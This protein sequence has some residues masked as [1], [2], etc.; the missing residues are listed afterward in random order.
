MKKIFRLAAIF[1][2]ISIILSYM[3]IR[4]ADVTLTAG[5]YAF[6]TSVNPDSVST[7]NAYT[8]TPYETT[9]SAA[10]YSFNL[11]NLSVPEGKYIESAMLKMQ[12]YKNTEYTD[13]DIL[14]LS[15]ENSFDS[16]SLTYNTAPSLGGVVAKKSEL[17][18]A[19]SRIDR[20]DITPYVCEMVS[21]GSEFV[22]FALLNYGTA[23]CKFRVTGLEITYTDA[24]EE[25]S[26]GKAKFYKYNMA[27]RNYAVNGEHGLD[28]WVSF[29]VSG[30][31]AGKKLNV[32][33]AS[34]TEDNVMT[35]ITKFEKTV[36]GGSQES[37]IA[38]PFSHKKEAA[39]IRAFVW[40][41]KQSPYA[42]SSYYTEKSVAQLK[43][44]SISAGELAPVFSRDVYEYAILF[45]ELPESFPEIKLQYDSGMKVKK[46]PA[47]NLNEPYKVEVT[48]PDYNKTVTYSFV[49]REKQTAVISARKINSGNGELIFPCD[50]AEDITNGASLEFDK[51]FI[52]GEKSAVSEVV[53][54]LNLKASESGALEIYTDSSLENKLATLDIKA[55]DEF[56]PYSVPLRS[57]FFTNINS[58]GLFIKGNAEL[59]T[60]EN[61]VESSEGKRIP[62]IVASYGKTESEKENTLFWDDRTKVFS[63][64]Y[65]YDMLP[66]DKYLSS[67]NPPTFVWPYIDFADSYQF[68][69][70]KDAELKNIVAY[71][72]NANLNLQT[73]PFELEPGNYYWTVRG[74]KGEEFTEWTDVRRVTVLSDAVASP[75]PHVDE[76]KEALK[77]AP[78]PR[79][80]TSPDKIEEFRAL[81]DKGVESVYSSIISDANAAV[82]STVLYEPVYSG[83][84][85]TYK[86]QVT[87]I[88]EQID[89]CTLAYL[90]TGETKYATT[91]I[92]IMNSMAGWK[93][94]VD[95]DKDRVQDEGESSTYAIDSQLYRS[96]LYSLVIGYDS[97]WN[98]MTETQK[99][100]IG[101]NIA[102]RMNYLEH[103]ADGLQDAAYRLEYTSAI[104]HGWNG[105]ET[106]LSAAIALAGHSDSSD[107]ILDG[108]LPRYLAMNATQTGYQD[109]GYSGGFA[110]SSYDNE[111]Y[112]VRALGNLGIYDM[113]KSAQYRNLWKNY[114]YTVFNLT[115]MEFGDGSYGYGANFDSAKLMRLYARFSG[116][117]YAVW[118]YE[119][120]KLPMQNVMDVYFV[121]AKTDVKP[122]RPVKLPKAHA[123]VDSGYVAMHSDLE[124][125]D[126]ISLY[127]RS[128]P[129]GSAAHSHA[130]HNSFHIQGFGE[131]LAI[132]SGYYDTVSTDHSR[133]YK[134][135]TYAH[136]AITHSGGKGQANKTYQAKGKITNFL[137]GEY[138]DLTSG[139]ATETYNYYN[140]TDSKV[141]Y[142]KQ[143]DKALRHIIYIRPDC[144]IVIDDLKAVDNKETTFE[145]WLHAYEDINFVSD[146]NAAVIRKN[147]AELEAEILYPVN[148]VK[149]GKSTDFEDINGNLW[150]PE[151]TESYLQKHQRVWFTTPTVNETGIVSVI[152]VRKKN[153]E[154]KEYKT[155][156][157]DGYVKIS[158]ADG[159]VAYVRT[160]SS[161]KEI[162][163]GD[164]ISFNGAAFVMKD[165]EFM[166]VDGI[167]ASLNGKE[168]VSSDKKVSVMKCLNTVGISGMEDASVAVATDKV[169]KINDERGNIVSAN[170]DTLGITAEYESEK[171][172]INMLSGFYTLKLVTSSGN[173]GIPLTE[174]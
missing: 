29:P 133:E 11:Q 89:C 111:S 101:D 105:A 58:I 25:I 159:T 158:F 138:F 164:G 126:K 148:M 92:R 74:L 171:L 31:G 130:D 103:P 80:L 23:D 38:F 52:Y 35:E 115:A 83:N 165:D 174:Y 19:A 136:N 128:S 161:E 48:S 61:Y 67:Q 98:L 3:V 119:S 125:E 141:H 30:S 4:A 127:F 137:T 146:K 150:S 37:F 94:Y 121:A 46:L 122:E 28:M 102:A 32:S 57:E 156:N 65:E 152:N 114:F 113:C 85:S 149:S 95:T 116:S 166:L 50:S 79:L 110:Y 87:T 7:G 27:E 36:Y 12:L 93:L 66:Y 155:E 99:N 173:A 112:V 78:H 84:A 20:I 104:S 118:K 75:V 63:G 45:D 55:G 90:V 17:T 96:V 82:S 109:G 172:K 14:V 2:V 16:N 18:I 69:V 167:K 71:K 142:D 157:C 76:I 10:Y 144:F 139:D 64:Y 120:I 59:W 24:A 124:S 140:E 163:T 131:R 26:V 134:R 129:Y 39:Y 49:C 147:E 8:L 15:C 68:V 154:K 13:G 42:I 143:M 153:D 135:E 170:T 73:F 51:D 53:L 5:S 168:L 88:I 145:W 162:I 132:D 44:V 60:G 33:V 41:S 160:V 100:K 47:E 117:P 91:A 21:K 70:A 106:I 77:S 1:V 81:K 40:D 169:H 108:Y 6:V 43:S 54:N 22:S 62:Y 151:G 9:P 107:A 34:Y 56:L 97:F 123:F 72:N 86:T